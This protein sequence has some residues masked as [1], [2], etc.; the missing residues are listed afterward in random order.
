MVWSCSSRTRL[1]IWLTSNSTIC[2]IAAT[3]WRVGATREMMSAARY[4]PRDFSSSVRVRSTPPKTAVEASTATGENSRRISTCNSW[5]MLGNLAIS[6][7]TSST[8]CSSNCFMITAAF[9]GARSNSSPASFWS[10]VRLANPAALMTRGSAAYSICSCIDCVSPAGLVS[11]K[12]R[13]HTRAWNLHEV[14]PGCAFACQ[15]RCPVRESHPQRNLLAP[16]PFIGTI[17]PGL[18][19]GAEPPESFHERD[20]LIEVLRKQPVLGIFVIPE[21]ALDQ[22]CNDHRMAQRKLFTGLRRVDNQLDHRDGGAFHIAKVHH[23]LIATGIHG[24]G[25]LF[26]QAAGDCLRNFRMKFLWQF[27]DQGAFTLLEVFV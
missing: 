21:C 14:M 10:L 5:P 8:S 4:T 1:K 12:K 2:S 7:K 24:G 3:V 26:I 16:Y 22:I 18:E 23:E 25:K 27:Q 19:T 6:D 9:S 11:G 15:A 20:R 17:R 13:R